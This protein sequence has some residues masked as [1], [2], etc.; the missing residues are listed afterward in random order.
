MKI[1]FPEWYDDLYEFECDA[2]GCIL[3]IPILLNDNEI[4]LDIYTIHRLNQDL[5]LEEDKF[6]Y[7]NKIL[8]INIVNKEHIIN[9]LKN[10][11]NN[12]PALGQHLIQNRFENA[13][14]EAGGVA[15]SNVSKFILCPDFDYFIKN[16]QQIH[17]FFSLK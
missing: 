10:I 12:V 9:A 2:K 8:I 16:Q 6:I 11:Q 3:N 17:S 15:G 13:A 5:K 4:I 14:V 7:A 1:I